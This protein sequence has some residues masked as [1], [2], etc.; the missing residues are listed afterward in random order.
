MSRRGSLR[1]NRRGIGV[2]VQPSWNPQA[3]GEPSGL[4]G[5]WHADDVPQATAPRM[6][7]NAVAG[8]L[9][10][11]APTSPTSPTTATGVVFGK[12]G[13]LFDG[14]D[15]VQGATVANWRDVHDGTGCTLIFIVTPTGV[16]T[17]N[18]IFDTCD[19]SGVG[20]FLS[21]DGVN[22]RFVSQ[23]RNGAGV[24]ASMTGPGTAPENASYVVGYSYAEGAGPAEAE[25]FQDGLPIAQVNTSG[26]PD[27]GDSVGAG[28][29]GARTSGSSSGNCYIR[30]VLKYNRKLTASEMLR[31]GTLGRYITSN[32][33]QRNVLCVGESTTSGT[34]ETTVQLA[35]FMGVNYW[36]NFL[37]TL[38]AGSFPLSDFDNWG[39]TGQRTDQIQA[40]INGLNPGGVP[41]VVLLMACINDVL[42]SVAEPTIVTNYTALGQYLKNTFPNALHR[43]GRPNRTLGAFAA[44]M[45]SM[46]AQCPAIATAIGSTYVNTDVAADAEISGDLVHPTLAG[47]VTIGNAFAS[48]LSW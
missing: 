40:A 38:S 17:T 13:L 20:M 9:L 23:V 18:V 28:T 21:H 47:Y 32:R 31:I 36:V 34:Y 11:S 25:L 8:T 29:F 26:A 15:R 7:N 24:I 19:L 43:L 10:M 22:N 42:Q 6:P 1:D 48:S 30:A 2:G 14:T 44:A 46:A 45:S 33:Q 5:F 12:R 39:Y 41:D 37:G 4:I 16:G 35:A 27:L 3:A